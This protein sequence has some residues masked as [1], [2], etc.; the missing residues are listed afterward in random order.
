MNDANSLLMKGIE[1][2][3]V[4]M[5]TYEVTGEEEEEDL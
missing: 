4:L 2:A 3:F 5:T 1:D